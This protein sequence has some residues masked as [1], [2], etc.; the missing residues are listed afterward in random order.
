MRAATCGTSLSPRPDRFAT[1]RLSL[2]KF[3]RELRHVGQRMR[4]FERR[5]DALELAQKMEGLERLVVGRRDIFRAAAFLEPGMLR[6]DAGIVEAGR[7]RMRLGD[8][9]FLVLQEI[10]AIAVQHAGPAAGQRRG[11]LARLDAAARR[12]DADDAHALVVEE[13]ME[14]AHRVRAAADAGHQRVRDAALGFHHLRPRL[15]A[16]HALEVAHHRRIGMRA[17]HGADAVEGRLAGGDPV[18]QRLVHG[19]LERRGARRHRPHLRAQHLHAKDVGR[20]ALDVDRAHEHHAGN[21]EQRAGRRGG[22]AVLAGAGLGD[23]PRLAH[24][25]G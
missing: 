21:V 16:D 25:L 7:D 12:L 18:A 5:N 8:L 1:R 10:G 3:R 4:G 22:D 14:Q 9:A 11:M 19:V 23:H 13:G 17:G 6:P 24:P 15:L 20:L 2:G